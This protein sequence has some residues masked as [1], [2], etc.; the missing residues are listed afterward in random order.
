MKTFIKWAIAS[1]A[2]VLTLGVA[3]YMAFLAYVFWGVDLHYYL[4]TGGEFDST[5]WKE[6]VI[7]TGDRIRMADLLLERGELIGLTRQEVLSML[8]L[9]GGLKESDVIDAPQ[10]TYALGPE[11]G[12][13]A[14]S[15]EWLVL[16]FD[17]N[18]VVK[19]ARKRI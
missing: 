19:N 3:F 16:E 12:F 2:S 5:R 11:P 10:W 14:I 15:H 1:I 9:P 4:V 18:G 8:G 6:A 17:E 7:S 13:V